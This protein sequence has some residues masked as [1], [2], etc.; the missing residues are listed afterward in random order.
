M[1]KHTLTAQTRDVL[2]RKVKS[3]RTKG[4]MP[5]T[6]YGKNVKS[7]SVSLKMD[8]FLKV[9]REAG[10]SG[11]VELS[12][13]GG[14]KPVLIHNVQKDPVT[15]FSLH[16]ELRQVDLKEK[17][18]AT[19][20]LVFM[21]VSPVVEQKQGVL[22]T[23]LDEVDVE[24]L[25]ADLPEKIEIDVSGLAEIDQEITV[26]DVTVPKGAQI[27]TDRELTVVKV[28]P[29]VSKEVEAEQAAEAAA[30]AAAQ[31]EGEAAAGE[32][33]EVPAAEP[34]EGEEPLKP[35]EKEEQGDNKQ[36]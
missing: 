21:G 1:K 7:Q 26:G 22:I 3:L 6:I 33:A 12:L 30:A 14:T 25:P 31:A 32:G 16:A 11:L 9:F 35:I 10:E 24:A 2:G 13:T 5:A 23:V 4:L 36:P 29:L 28:G 17:V 27:Q 34:R 18:T 19:V 8:E 20:P 15:G